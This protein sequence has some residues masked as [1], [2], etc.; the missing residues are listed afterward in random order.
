MPTIRQIYT[1]YTKA[2]A[3][4]GYVITGKEL[5]AVRISWLADSEEK[6]PKASMNEEAVHANLRESLSAKRYPGLGGGT[7]GLTMDLALWWLRMMAAVGHE[8]KTKEETAQKTQEKAD[9]TPGR[10]RDRNDQR[11]RTPTGSETQDSFDMSMLRAFA[12]TPR[13]SATFCLLRLWIKLAGKLVPQWLRPPRKETE[14]SHAEAEI[15]V[16]QGGGS[17]LHGMSSTGWQTLVHSLKGRDKA[18]FR[19]SIW[20]S[21]SRGN[22]DAIDFLYLMNITYCCIS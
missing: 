2:N 4:Y 7:H 1:Y 15:E 21:C 18:P 16:A 19:Q 5:L 22:S 6:L 17:L 9:K 10:F 11:A 3:Q 14:R 20:W 8:I 12:P 13:R